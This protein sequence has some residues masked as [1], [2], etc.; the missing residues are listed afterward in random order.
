M[1]SLAGIPATAGFIGKIYLIEAVVNGG[2]AW[3][4]VII[5]IGS[6]I[7]LGYYL[8]VIAAMWMRESPE[9]VTAL[10]ANGRPVIAGGSEEAPGDGRN[11][12]VA[13]VAL[14]FGLATVFFGIVPQPLYDLAHHAASSL[15]SFL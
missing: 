7:S 2:Y 5:V 14:A 10:A 4:G 12:E 9:G 11:I 8:R 15:T 1:L 13:L 3:L 6:M